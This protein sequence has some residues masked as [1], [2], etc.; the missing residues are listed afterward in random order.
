[1]QDHVRRLSGRVKLEATVA[2]T[3]V[4]AP[5]A[6]PDVPVLLDMSDV[7]SQK[8]FQYSAT[9]KP[10][11]LFD[12]VAKRLR[13]QEILYAE[14]S[15]RTI[16]IT[17]QE[18]SLLRSFALR[19]SATYIEN[20]VDFSRFNP[21]TAPEIPALRGRTFLAFVGAMDY[22]PN[23]Q[24]VMWFAKEVWGE[25]RKRTPKLEL[26]IIGRHPSRDVTALGSIPGIWLEA[27]PPDVVPF[28]S[29]SAAVIAPLRM[30]RGIQNKVLEG[31]AMGK[32]VFSST[33]ICESL[34]ADLPR[35]VVHCPSA[36]EFIERI[37]SAPLAAGMWDPGIRNEAQT[38][39]SWP[40]AMERLREEMTAIADPAVGLPL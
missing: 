18:C 11:F 19:A 15:R 37:S 9:R 7:D 26:G 31:L 14:S 33:P 29:A 27:S 20:G 23:V 8:W 2:Y 24:A 10:A 17:E 13:K 32:A 6:P 28:L 16:L 36:T 38:R 21:A 1:M 34:G 30:A 5:Y 12:A 39:F 22:Y 25:L 35:G 4:M 3:T 40:R